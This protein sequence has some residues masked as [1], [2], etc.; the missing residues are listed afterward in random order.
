VIDLGER[1]QNPSYISEELRKDVRRRVAKMSASEY[2]EWLVRH[3]KKQQSSTSSKETK[4]KSL[5]S[6]RASIL[7]SVPNIP[8]VVSH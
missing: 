7:R 5:Q 1:N 8:C 3:R 4:W 6:L 2:N